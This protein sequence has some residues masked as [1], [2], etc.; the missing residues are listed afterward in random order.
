MTAAIIMVLAPVKCPHCGSDNIKKN[1][2]SKNSKQRFLCSNE[3]LTPAYSTPVSDCY[4]ADVS[5]GGY[6]LSAGYQIAASLRHQEGRLI[7]SKFFGP[8]HYGPVRKPDFY[9]PAPLFPIIEKEEGFFL[10]LFSVCRDSYRKPGAISAP[11]YNIGTA[12]G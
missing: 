5:A 9:H 3:N 2:T 12:W 7:A 11:Q 6:N 8:P 1:R 4:S 10:T